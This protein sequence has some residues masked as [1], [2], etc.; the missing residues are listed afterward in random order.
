MNHLMLFILRRELVKI[1]VH[2]QIAFAAGIH[3]AEEQWLKEQLRSTIQ[4]RMFQVGTVMPTA[5]RTE[6]QHLVPL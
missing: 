3:R 5:S 4:F 2:L 1:S 6:G